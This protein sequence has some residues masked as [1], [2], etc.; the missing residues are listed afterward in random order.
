MSP[1]LSQFGRRRAVPETFVFLQFL[2]LGIDALAQALGLFVVADVAF[3]FP[4]M[5]LLLVMA[6]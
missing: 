1:S 3:F 2:L 5:L 4:D 6:L